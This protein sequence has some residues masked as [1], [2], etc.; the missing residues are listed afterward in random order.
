M[1]VNNQDD[2]RTA[3]YQSL[4]KKAADDPMRYREQYRPQYH[5]SNFEGWLNDPNGL[6]YYEGEYHLFFQQSHPEIE[7]K[8]WGH[9]VSRD[10]M[11]WEHLP[12]ALFRDEL[13]KIFSGSA[14]VDWHDTSGFFQGG[15]GLV[16]IYSYQ[17]EGESQGI[18]YSRDRGRTW[19][20]YEG[21]P[22]IP[23]FQE[24]QYK[25]NFRDPKVIWYKPEK[26]WIMVVGTK[27]LR[28]YSSP[29]LKEWTYESELDRG[30]SECPDLFE[31]PVDGDHRN[32]KWVLCLTGG[33]AYEI[34]SFDGHRFTA[35]SQRIRGAYRPDAYAMQSWSDIPDTDGRRIAIYW[36]NGLQSGNKDK[37]HP[38]DGSMT[39]PHA[40]ELKTF[41]DG[42][43]MIQKPVRELEALRGKPY[44]LSNVDITEELITLGELRG[45]LL[46]IIAE[47]ELGTAE[48][49]GLV[50]RKGKGLKKGEMEQTVIGY[51]K[52]SGQLFIDRTQSGMPT[53]VDH[54]DDLAE[55]LNPCGNTIKIHA[56][57]DRNSVEIFGNDGET[58]MFAMILPSLTSD[59]TGV[60]A[61]GGSVALKKLEAYEL[62][63]IWYHDAGREDPVGVVLIHDSIEIPSG[64]EINLGATIAGLSRE[65]SH[66]IWSSDNPET[67]SVLSADE[68]YATLKTVNAGDAV[69]TAACGN[70]GLKGQC[71]VHVYQSDFRSNITEWVGSIPKGWRFVSDGLQGTGDFR[72]FYFARGEWSD[73]VLHADLEVMPDSQAGLIVRCNRFGNG[74]KVMV[75]TDL[76]TIFLY[77]HHDSQDHTLASVPLQI[78]H[79]QRIHLTFSVK[80]NR[81]KVYC[82][83]VLMMEQDL[84]ITHLDKRHVALTVD[85]GTALF[86][87]ISVHTEL[88]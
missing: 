18:A 4:M 79:P 43:K 80:G 30:N 1:I 20:K 61:K 35:E 41:P 14:V 55:P 77:D 38:W 86:Q 72:N 8:N 46:E 75:N 3:I 70:G 50:V 87:S 73:V 2:P 36:A 57:V 23:E 40:I 60:Y 67:V 64:S 82:E 51:R 9:A 47:F 76:N 71:K 26:K 32:K 48:E 81:A 65:K 63:P 59:G 5:F 37:T 44:S 39:L 84:I 11:H 19:I 15:S 58:T 6:V 34:G 29:N 54:W 25:D 49:F 12:I 28:L 17:K 33:R 52:G 83:D 85:R 10:L 66:L 31:L 68:R 62:N 24:P 7:G 78:N 56:F 21:N 42:I 13:G 88:E 27:P 74:I 45:A 69:I 22:V 53:T 16:A